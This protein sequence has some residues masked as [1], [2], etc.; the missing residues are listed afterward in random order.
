MLWN[1]TALLYLLFK[2]RSTTIYLGMK[3]MINSEYFLF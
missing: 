2:N 1:L 3:F